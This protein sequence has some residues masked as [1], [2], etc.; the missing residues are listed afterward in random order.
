MESGNIKFEDLGGGSVSLVPRSRVWERAMNLD[1]D[2][3]SSH[4]QL[5]AASVPLLVVLREWGA[6]GNDAYL[7]TEL[8]MIILQG[9]QA[10]AEWRVRFNLSSHFGSMSTD[11]SA[12]VRVYVY[13]RCK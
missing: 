13:A 2:C 12:Y 9:V 4:P 11:S 7:Q 6:E 1:V 8:L 5:S 3:R 10:A